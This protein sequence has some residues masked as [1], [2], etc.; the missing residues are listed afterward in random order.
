MTCCNLRENFLVS[1][2]DKLGTDIENAIDNTTDLTRNRTIQIQ[3]TIGAEKRRGGGNYHVV[4]FQGSL[5]VF[6]MTHLATHYLQC[7]FC[8]RL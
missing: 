6:K 5:I 8:V 1:A 4:I 3:N 7:I 2:N